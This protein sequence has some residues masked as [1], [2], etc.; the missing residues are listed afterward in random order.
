MDVKTVQEEVSEGHVNDEYIFYLKNLFIEEI[1]KGES[2]RVT[3]ALMAYAHYLNAEGIN[4]D[5][6]PLYLKILESNNKYAIDSMIEGHEAEHYL[7]VVTPNRYLVETIFSIF[8]SYRRNELYA[9][10][11]RVLLG[12]L[13][14]VYEQA[15]VG[16]QVYQPSIADVNNLGKIL[17]ETKDQDD[18][19]NRDILDVLMFLSDLDTHHETDPEKKEIA[20]QSGRIRSDY[21]D[22]QRKLAQSITE[23]ILEEADKVSYGIAPEYIYITA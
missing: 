8:S 22:N 14:K 16:W 13:L 12:F 15:E 1:K 3:S 23:V 5:N 11:L 4:S 19:L 20:R 6:Y 18:R 17:D 21:F 2:S 10:T 9:K 7:D